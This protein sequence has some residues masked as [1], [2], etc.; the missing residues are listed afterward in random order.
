MYLKRISILNYRN[1]A[2]CELEF[3]PKINC[4]L[5]RNGMGKTNLLDAVY[6]L[7]FCKSHLN[8]IDSQVIKHDADFFMLQGTFERCGADEVVSCAVKRR[9]KKRFKRNQKEYERLSDHIGFVPVVLVAPSDADLVSEGSDYR[10]RFLD[11]VIA[12]YD[13]PYLDALIRYNAALQNRNALLKND[14]A[15]DET[16]FDIYESQMATEAAYIYEKRAA[17][18][19]N[20]VPIFQQFYG[21]IAADGEQVGIAFEAH[22]QQGDLQPQLRA[23]RDRDRLLGYSSRGA[24]RDDLTLT[25][26]D[27]PMKRTGSQG[28]VKTFTVAL[29]LAQYLFLKRICG[30]KP[31][32]LLDDI[33]DKLD[34]DRVTRIVQIV[35][36][37]DFGQIFITDTNSS[38]LDE[39]LAQIGGE[40]RLFNVVDGAVAKK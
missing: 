17:F 40:Q 24:H 4:F 19:A 16:M 37:D 14:S 31:L 7:S 22:A 39:I 1:I 33:F 30:V 34:S 6:Y 36:S 21:K 2:E 15:D 25:L 3:S 29:K 18:V 26:G 20:F 13:K 10:R 38:H 11:T 32:L 8:P 5:G 35:G 12:Q 28:Q 9:A 27:Y 23:V